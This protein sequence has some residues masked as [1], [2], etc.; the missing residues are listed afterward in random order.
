VAGLRV[1][2]PPRTADAGGA[3]AG[4]IEA[5]TSPVV[6][7]IDPIS[8]V[9]GGAEDMVRDQPQIDLELGGPETSG[10]SSSSSLR[11]PR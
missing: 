7:D 8:V 5:T 6:I 2:I 3:S 10:A 4:G 9:P 1:E 11:F